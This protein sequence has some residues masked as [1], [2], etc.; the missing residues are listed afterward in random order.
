MT[1]T[2]INGT[3]LI[4][5]RETHAYL[6]DG[7][8]E[9]TVELGDR[10]FWD[11]FPDNI[12]PALEPLKEA[13]TRLGAKSVHLAF[14]S[15]YMGLGRT[16]YGLRVPEREARS[17]LLNELSNQ[18]PTMT[19]DV[20]SIVNHTFRVGEVLCGVWSSMRHARLSA[21]KS[22]FARLGI[23]L[24][25][26]VHPSL[27]LV[28]ALPKADQIVLHLTPNCLNVMCTNSAGDFE[29]FERSQELGHRLIT[30]Q[31]A[32]STAE[33]YA[34]FMQDP[35]ATTLKPIAQLLQN[36]VSDASAYFGGHPTADR[37]LWLC[38]PDLQDHST[39]E[40]L[41]DA[42]RLGD[43]GLEVKVYP[44]GM[45]AVAL[46]L[47][48]SLNRRSMNVNVLK[49]PRKAAESLHYLKPA[50]LAVLCASGLGMATH[51][52]LQEM[53]LRSEANRKS[54]LQTAIR[55]L[56][57]YR[58]FAL[59]LRDQNR[60]QEALLSLPDLELGVNPNWRH[61]I[62]SL[63]ANLPTTAK[64]F[65]VV[66]DSLTLRK[67]GIGESAQYGDK[68]IAVVAEVSGHALN[69]G[70]LE[71]F[72]R[73]FEQSQNFG[74]SVQAVNYKENTFNANIGMLAADPLNRTAAPPP[75]PNPVSSAPPT[76]ASPPVNTPQ[77]EVKR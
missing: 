47:H 67:A 31:K 59:A 1:N 75:A 58:M 53:R 9:E 42:L 70:A 35:H 65:D 10:G 20:Q 51:Y 73:H 61:L 17:V 14:D 76:T 77:N 43:L 69:R 22:G 18:D 28:N 30:V 13:L 71:R 27:A 74:L 29:V 25:S 49:A 39:T 23:S 60:S 52:G 2:R 16:T 62:E 15:S 54:E 44:G 56:E 64:G 33:S 72:V 55:S 66:L 63:I 3:V 24:K 40:R 6:A 50:A 21:L 34:R 46:A 12:D 57:P 5:I 32:N 36:T 8:R 26:V 68:P 45:H 19:E 48:P 7:E 4:E 11:T 41:S 37:T 38:G